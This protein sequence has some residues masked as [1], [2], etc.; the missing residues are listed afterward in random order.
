MNH[1]EPKIVEFQKGQRNFGD[2]LSTEPEHSD[3]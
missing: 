1:D 3:D 2:T